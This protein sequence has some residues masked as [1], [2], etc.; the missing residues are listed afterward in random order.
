[1]EWAEE[2]IQ[3]ELLSSLSGAA[4]SYGSPR[5]RARSSGH[6]TPRSHNTGKRPHNVQYLRGS[7]SGCPVLQTQQNQ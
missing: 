5:K 1:M 4:Q 3:D 6:S 7:T 2:L